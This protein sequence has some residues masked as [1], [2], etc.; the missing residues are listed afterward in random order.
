MSLHNFLSDYIGIQLLGQYDAVVRS[1]QLL[2][3]RF[4]MSV[5]NALM[6]TD[7]LPVSF[8]LHNFS[9]IFSL[10]FEL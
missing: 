2:R 1:L 4:T 6:Q 5:Q 7:E 9:L 10:S 3:E 8:L